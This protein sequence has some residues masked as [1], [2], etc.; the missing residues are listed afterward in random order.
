LK[1][2]NISIDGYSG[3]GKS[4]TAK[5]VA[6]R[7]D[8]LYIDS[9]AMYR[10]VTLYFIENEIDHTIPEKVTEALAGISI[11]FSDEGVCLNGRLVANE[12]RTMAVNHKVSHIAAI[13]SVRENMVRQQQT[14]GISKGVVMDGR[15]IGTVVFPNAELKVFMTANAD[16]RAS[17]RQLELA[18][19]GV[20][21]DL[22]TIKRNLLER[23]RIDSSR[24]ESPL[25]KAIDA[26]EVDTSFISLDEQVEKIVKLAKNVI[27]EN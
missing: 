2:I 24:E 10:A 20:T 21:E 6:S 5:K 25:V 1:K 9:G 12:I 3:T 16:V 26:I 11:S 18:E 17:R 15:D 19:N 13:K 8:Y 27:N 14:I 22:N 4:S 23:D 7:L